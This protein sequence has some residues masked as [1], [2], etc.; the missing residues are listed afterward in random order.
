MSTVISLYAPTGTPESE[1]RAAIAAAVAAHPTAVAAPSLII[2]Q[3]DSFDGYSIAADF[4]HPNVDELALVIADVKRAIPAARTDS[5]IDA[6]LTRA[7][8]S[9]A[10]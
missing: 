4:F 5:E 9:P 2:E 3:A 8:A 7:K 10:A 1:F 6:A